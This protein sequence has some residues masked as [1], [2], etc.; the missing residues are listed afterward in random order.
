[1]APIDLHEEEVHVNKRVVESG[2][3]RVGTRVFTEHK[4]LEV[5]VGR[6]VIEIRRW[7][8][9][10]PHLADRPVQAT[11]FVVQAFRDKV[12]LE[13]HAVV[14]ER[15]R[16]DKRRIEEQQTVGTERRWE[17]LSVDREDLQ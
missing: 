3:V 1:M 5:P 17:E 9:R 8:V 7:P 10:E 16:V 13:K 12:N 2:R 15:V 14:R 6:D 4:E 11:E